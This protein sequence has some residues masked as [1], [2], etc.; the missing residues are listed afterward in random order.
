MGRRDRCGL[1][2]C[3]SPSDSGLALLAS[4]AASEGPFQGASGSLVDRFGTPWMTNA[5]K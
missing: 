1:F 3:R 2:A 4:G 5:I